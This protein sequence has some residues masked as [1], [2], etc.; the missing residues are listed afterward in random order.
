MTER[1]VDGPRVVSRNEWQNARMNLL[2]VEKELTR[3]RDALNLARRTLPAV[4]VEADYRFTGPDGDASLLDLF[5]GRR[6]LIV[7]HMM[8]APG[9][10]APCAGCAYQADSIGELAH[11]HARDTTLVAVSRAP[12]AKLAAFARRMGWT[13]PWFSSFGSS[14]N[15]DFHV[16][17]DARIAPVEW[18]YRTADEL[19]A[20]GLGDV[21]EME[22]LNGISVF[23]RG[24]DDQILHTYSTY[25]RGVE[26]LL[27]TYMW[28]DLTPL[29]RQEGWGGTPDRGR[30]W[31]RFHD[32]YAGATSGGQP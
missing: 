16:S 21:A 4:R 8:F 32:E 26:L 23:L 14:F 18:N 9:W 1:T 24:E 31:V 19:R 13:F 7:V 29:G 12:Q 15:Y 17:Q 10:D 5:D 27:D 30:D 2:A 20:A 11:L 3:A 6:Q 25:G 28:L 22:E